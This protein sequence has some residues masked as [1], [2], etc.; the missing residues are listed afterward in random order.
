[1]LIWAF[2]FLQWL[3]LS[4]SKILTFHPA[5]P[6]ILGSS[7][8]NMP[9]ITLLVSRS[10]RWLLDFW[11][12][13]SVVL[14]VLHYLTIGAAMCA[15]RFK[16][17]VLVVFRHIVIFVMVASIPSTD[18][19]IYV[20]DQ[21]DASK[22]VMNFTHKSCSSRRV[23]WFVVRLFSS[24]TPTLCKTCSDTA[25]IMHGV[26]QWPVALIFVLVF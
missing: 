4:P 25:L 24:V 20:W 5:S 26:V 22:T 18:C 6:C 19:P 2:F 12:I 7:V 14:M 11:K 3:I 16:I 8:W 21:S 13:C 9:H 1:M 10:I 17:L 15:D 23:L